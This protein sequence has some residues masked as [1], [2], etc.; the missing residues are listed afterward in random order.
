[1]QWTVVFALLAT[2]GCSSKKMVP[3]PGTGGNGAED[4]GIACGNGVVDDTED[5]DEGMNNGVSGGSC[6]A[7]CQFTCSV[8]INCDDKD[9]CNGAEKCVDHACKPG[10]AADDGTTCGSA[11]LCRGGTCVDSKCGDGIVTAPEECDDGNITAGDGC[12]NNCTYSCVSSDTTRNCTPADACAG[13]G[14]CN[15]TT[16]VCAAGTPLGD[17]TM[18]GGMPNDYCSGGKCTVPMCGNGKTEPG[19]QCDDAGLNGT[20]NSGCKINCTFACVTPATDCGTPDACE[21]YTCSTAHICT[22][23]ADPAQNGNSCPGGATYV[24]K[25]GACAPPTSVCGN[26]TVETGEDCDFG[27]A[28]NGPNKGCEAN[29]KFS[30]TAAASCDDGNACN[31]TESCDPVTVGTGNGKKCNAGTALGDGTAC[32]TGKIC[33]TRVCQNSTCG[34]GYIDAGKGETCEPPSSATCDSMCHSIVCGDGVRAASE[35]CDDGN[36]TNLD[37]CD[38]ACKFEQEQRATSLVM[39]WDTNVC[40]KNALGTAIVDTTTAQPQLQTALANGVK[41]G[42]ISILL[43]FLGLD[44][45]TGTASTLPFKL[46][47]FHA[48][49]VAGTGYDGTNDVDWW[50]TTDSMSIDGNRDPN[51]SL[52]NGKFAAGGNLSSDPGMVKL[53]LLLAGSPAIITMYNT[54]MTAKSGASTAPKTSTGATPGHLASE[55]LNP[56]LTSFQTLTGGKLCGDI[57]AGSLNVGLPMALDGQCDEGYTIAGGSTLLD[58]IVHGCKKTVIVFAVTVIKPTQPDTSIDG[59]TYKITTTGT[60]VTGCTGGAAWP[61]CL[62]KAT[63]TSAFSFTADRIIAK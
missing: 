39:S 23:V 6:T 26:G 45:L 24:C 50:Y 42:T 1:M 40:A 51:T 35:Q 34:D 63:Y 54:K 31:G 48:T 36:K 28:N 10:T 14:T 4:M 58:V 12:E 55:H 38:S 25:D 11:K 2:I 62:D 46:G 19:E 49:Q 59:N 22:Q 18:C 61:T 32:G 7:F 29:C 52:M 57:T 43:K 37:G 5:C 9:T 21:K 16:H 27:T 3:D 60:K 20:K 47:V 44:D 56:A 13:K 41:D 17:G 30:C 15:D 53:N 8:D 33:L